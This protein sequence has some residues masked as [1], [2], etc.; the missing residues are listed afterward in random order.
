[1]GRE[2]RRGSERRGHLSMADSYWC[3]AKTSQ[4]YK[5]IILQL[6]KEKEKLLS[7]SPMTSTSHFFFFFFLTFNGIIER[8]INPKVRVESKNRK[9]RRKRL[10]KRCVDIKVKKEYRNE[11]SFPL[12]VTNINFWLTTNLNIISRVNFVYLVN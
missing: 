3:M 2:V 4:Y 8:K 1:M 7:L 12:P 6:K 5:A 9:R 11:D 10:L